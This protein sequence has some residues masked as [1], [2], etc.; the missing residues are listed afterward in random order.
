MIMCCGVLY[1]RFYKIDDQSDGLIQ[2]HFVAVWLGLRDI[3]NRVCNQI[4]NKCLQ[5]DRQS[6]KAG[7]CFAGHGVTHD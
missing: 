6:Q 5:N 3:K 4:I 2:D 7:L 1:A